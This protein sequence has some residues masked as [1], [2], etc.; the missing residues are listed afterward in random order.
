MAK[1]ANEKFMAPLIP[2][3]AL[4]AV[5]GSEPLSRPDCMKKI[6]VYIKENNLQDSANKRNINADAKLEK[7][8]GGKKKI[9]MFEIAGFMS[10]H[11]SKPV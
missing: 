5:I 3:E 2:S 9:G 6:W 1:K 7:V 4:A 11:L 8:F 10:Q